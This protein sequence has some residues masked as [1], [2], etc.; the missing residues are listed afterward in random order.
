MKGVT[1]GSLRMDKP[2]HAAFGEKH[3]KGRKQPTQ[4]PEQAEQGMVLSGKSIGEGQV[5]KEN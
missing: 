5:D 4:R 3:S 2:G 1:F